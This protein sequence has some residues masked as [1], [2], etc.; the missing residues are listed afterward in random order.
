MLERR[1]PT[2]LVLALSFATAVT[3]APAG[4][5]KAAQPPAGP[6]P[7]QTA[8]LVGGYPALAIAGIRRD[9]PRAQ[10]LP[11]LVRLLHGSPKGT[12]PHVDE[13]RDRLHGTL[14]TLAAVDDIAA[15]W[16]GGLSI[17]QARD[18]QKKKSLETALG[19]L[20][21]E[22]H[23]QR[24]AF[25]VG[26]DGGG[27]AA[28]LRKT[29]AAA[30]VAV[31]DIRAGLNAGQTVRIP[32]PE[33]T[34]PVPMPRSA[35]ETLVFHRATPENQWV[36]ALLDDPQASLLAYGMLALDDE[37]RGWLAGDRQLLGDAVSHPEAFTLVAPAFRVTG[38]TLELPGGAA[39]APAWEAVAGAKPADPKRF[40][41]AL[42]AADEGRL[43]F[44][45]AT[46]ASLDEPHLRLVLGAAGTPSRNALRWAYD[47]FADPIVHW[48]LVGHPFA[49]GRMD[50]AVILRTLNV[51][52]SGR[53]L[54]PTWERVWQSV[55]DSDNLGMKGATKGLER[56]RAIDG[57]WI[58]ERILSLPQ[59]E[60]DARL[61][62]LLFAQR[63]FPHPQPQDA[64]DLIVAL[65]GYQRFPAVAAVLERMG[66]T[67]PATYAAVMR[68]AEQAAEASDERR[69]AVLSQFQG[70]LALLDR[71]RLREAIAAADAERAALDLAALVPEDGWYEGR[72]AAWIDRTL[73]SLAG[74]TDGDADLR[75]RR[76]L[77]ALAGVRPSR[78]PAVF[79]WEEERYQVAFADAERERIDTIVTQQLRP[80]VAAVLR[81]SAAV[82]ALH[83]AAT[84][85]ALRGATADLAQLLGSTAAPAKEPQLYGDLLR[86]ARDA[87]KDLQKIDE[88][89]ELKKAGPAVQ[90]VTRLMDL[91][92]AFVLRLLDYAVFMP[93]EDNGSIADV[94]ARHDFG[95]QTGATDAVRARAA[96]LAPSEVSEEGGWRLRGSL[97]AMDVATGRFAV[98][99]L[100]SAPPTHPPT[101][102]DNT[103]L[104][105]A[106]TLALAQSAPMTD[107]GRDAIAAA[108][109]LGRERVRAAASAP[110]TVIPAPT[111]M[112]AWRREAL[113]WTMANDPEQLEAQFTT[114]ELYALGVEATPPAPDSWGTAQTLTSGCLCLKLVAL[115]PWEELAGRSGTTVAV[116][117]ASDLSLRL[118]EHMSALNVPAELLPAVLAFATGD[119]IENAESRFEEDSMAL[120]R[121][122][123]A[124]TRQH[125]EDIV[126]SVVGRGLARPQ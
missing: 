85:E 108:I 107:A 98:R 126:A 106:Q 34:V 62:V 4:A 113:A 58:M 27:D 18:K 51:D 5:P 33:V 14:M 25:D 50:G 104:Q 35:W 36:A 99:R 83:T 38:K 67:A 49:H 69:P 73:T 20:G 74:G 110:G 31:N 123:R 60:R 101:L 117:S 22:L 72:V 94:A 109:A 2:L 115:T 82:T 11:T 102:V 10:V 47:G 48:T 28:A 52:A 95:G 80:D 92:T 68:G 90:P 96:W 105:L 118:A 114:R 63:A 75:Q 79:T 89:K 15:A 23:E 45:F 32:V 55:F 1:T 21:L 41:R 42:V 121:A 71:L 86:D 124:I 70:A 40:F 100:S 39:A 9:V 26:E 7:L 120:S 84:V 93:S 43:A 81:L 37:T 87:V 119:V 8:R 103:R 53:L 76:L 77:D 44:F 54:G 24:G 78:Q 19:S 64:A 59:G 12:D 125:V 16:P 17:A 61:E 88:A 56:D 122:A 3:A 66:V 111:G 65:R 6:Q 13:I 29:L 112:S 46:I 30:G 97:L 116:A 91:Q 57:H